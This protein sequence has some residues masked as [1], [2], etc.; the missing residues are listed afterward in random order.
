MTLK[1][2]DMPFIYRPTKQGFDFI[3]ALTKAEDLD[4]FSLKSVQIVIDSHASYWYRR[5][6][7]FYGLPMVINLAVFWFWSNVVLVNLFIDYETFDTWDR[8]C[9]MSLLITGFY[10]LSMELSAVFKRRI[11]YFTDMSRLFNIITPVLI[12]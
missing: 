11:L 2:L 10:L 1:Y 12:V 9:R 8:I 5:N 6:H 7:L 4:L 3:Y